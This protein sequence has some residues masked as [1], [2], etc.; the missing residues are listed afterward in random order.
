VATAQDA[1]SAPERQ[2]AGHIG[3]SVNVH[4]HGDLWGGVQ[5]WATREK[6]TGDDLA[7][8]I[9][10]TVG[11]SDPSDRSFVKS[12]I[13]KIRSLYREYWCD[14]FTAAYSSGYPS[15]MAANLDGWYSATAGLPALAATARWEFQ[16]V[17]RGLSTV[18]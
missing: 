17:S 2:P 8:A 12:R 9:R 7:D 16:P 3:C 6:D 14:A 11:S 5:A 1:P 4:R 18:C 13:S 10:L 15:L